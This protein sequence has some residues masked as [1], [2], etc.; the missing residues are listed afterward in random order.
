MECRR[1][2]HGIL[3]CASEI[4]AIG[5]F[6]R[7][8]QR[9]KANRK[10]LF[11]FLKTHVCPACI[12]FT[13]GKKAKTGSCVRMLAKNC[14]LARVAVMIGIVVSRCQLLSNHAFYLPAILSS[15][16]DVGMHLRLQSKRTRTNSR[17]VGS[18]GRR[19]KRI[20]GR[21]D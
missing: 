1:M 6:P 10:F 14:Q 19:A 21:H 17:R 2:Q 11:R 5:R 13:Y 16:Y 3:P 4:G 12:A 7:L 18:S 20:A 9:K 15:V 8:R